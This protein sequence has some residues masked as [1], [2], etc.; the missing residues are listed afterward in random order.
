MIDVVSNQVLRQSLP[1]RANRILERLIVGGMSTHIVFYVRPY[2]FDGFEIWRLRRKVLD[3]RNSVVVT[4]VLH[5]VSPVPRHA[6]MN[7]L[8]AL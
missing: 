2:V 3:Y 7:E 1:G 4:P 8:L 5:C 6:V